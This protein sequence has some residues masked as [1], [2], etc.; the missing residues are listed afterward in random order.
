MVLLEFSMFPLGA[1][2]SV[3]DAVADC[4][5]IV[6]KSGL[7]W[8][9]HAMGT[10]IEGE[11]KDVMAVVEKC[12]RKLAKDH[13]RISCSIKI[14]WRRGRKGTIASK[15]ASVERRLARKGR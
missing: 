6:E 13:N 10:E 7:P 2:E 9:L 4:V 12:W 3:G 15:V 1:G 14:D 8:K 5:R 11:W